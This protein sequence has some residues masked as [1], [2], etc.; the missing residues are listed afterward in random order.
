MRSRGRRPRQPDPSCLRS[1]RIVEIRG[2]SG[3]VT[4][5]VQSLWDVGDWKTKTFTSRF[6]ADRY[7]KGLLEGVDHI[8]QTSV[9]FSWNY[10]DDE[11]PS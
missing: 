2:D 8:D 9:V 5:E 7:A 10:N 11:I 4:Y 6:D 3:P 1:L